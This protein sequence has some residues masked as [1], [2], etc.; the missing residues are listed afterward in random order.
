M[1]IAPIA[2]RYFVRLKVSSCQ[3]GLIFLFVIDIRQCFSSAFMSSLV[4]G[5][6]VANSSTT[7]LSVIVAQNST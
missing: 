6:G 7:L 1:V 3:K 5:F 2:N 4:H